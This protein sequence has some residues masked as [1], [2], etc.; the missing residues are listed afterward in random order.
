MDM[1]IERGIGLGL[2]ELERKSQMGKTTK[3][4]RQEKVPLANTAN[5]EV[6]EDVI[7]LFRLL[8]DAG[9]LVRRG[10]MIAKLS[11]AKTAREAGLT[12]PTLRRIERDYNCQVDGLL[13]LLVVI[14]K[15]TNAEF[16]EACRRVDEEEAEETEDNK[17]EKTVGFPDCPEGACSDPDDYAGARTRKFEDDDCDYGEEDYGDGDGDGEEDYGEEE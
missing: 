12:T 15:A 1:R 13:S 14:A 16:A 10:R 4:N 2:A 17:E 5:D 8:S 9:N 11:E 7:T 3:E 6:I